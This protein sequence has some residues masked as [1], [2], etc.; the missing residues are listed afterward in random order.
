LPAPQGCI[1]N[2]ESAEPAELADED[3]DA[4]TVMVDEVADAVTVPDVDDA[5]VVFDEEVKP[6]LHATAPNK[7]V[8]DNNKKNC[9]Y[10]VFIINCLND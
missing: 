8:T 9:L 7:H 3:A 4:A 2:I 10:T 6:L 1:I 5:V